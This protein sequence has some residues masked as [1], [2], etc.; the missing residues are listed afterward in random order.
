[1]APAN[2]V[3][4]ALGTG[5]DIPSSNQCRQCHLLVG[6]NNVDAPIGFNAIQL[7]HTSAGVTLEALLQRGVLQNVAAPDSPNVTLENSVVPGTPEQ[8]AGL[9]YLHGNCSHCHGGPGPHGHQLLW[10]PVG[11]ANLTDLPMFGSGRTGAVCHCLDLW[12]GH[13]NGSAPYLLRIAPGSG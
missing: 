7:N 11:T 2:G 3:P 12:R 6:T 13:D 10:T 8:R 1:V 5:F 9:G 4:N